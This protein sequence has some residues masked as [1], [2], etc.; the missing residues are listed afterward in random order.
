MFGGAGLFGFFAFAA[1]TTAAI[2][3]L[4]TFLAGWPA[5][6]VVAAVYAPPRLLTS[7]RR[8]AIQGPGRSSSAS[9]MPTRASTDRP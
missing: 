5:A 4:G 8:S 6:L 2:L 7:S 1:L 9:R 3:A